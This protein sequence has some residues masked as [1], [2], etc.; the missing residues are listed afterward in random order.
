MNQQ[1]DPGGGLHGERTPEQIEREIELTRERMSRD[2]DA[3][4]DKLSPSNLKREAKDAL[5]S[6]LVEFARHHPLPVA[7]AG[8][9]A[10]WLMSRGDRVGRIKPRRRS[11]G[12]AADNPLA[13]AAGAAILGVC[14]GIL[15]SPRKREAGWTRQT[16]G[17]LMDRAKKAAKDLREEAP[18]IGEAATAVGAQ[19]KRVAKRAKE[20]AR[21]ATRKE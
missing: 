13:V 20:E 2:L 10:A 5:G 1:G 16:G 7:A 4:G 12:F 15:V 8:L 19:V 21:R 17:K 6:G 18:S 14:V 3:L 11:R 9:G